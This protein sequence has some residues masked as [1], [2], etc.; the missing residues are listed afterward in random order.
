MH[1]FV[2]FSL[3]RS[4]DVFIAAAGLGELLCALEDI[5]SGVRI[6]KVRRFIS[7]YL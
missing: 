4:N 5:H 3:E 6:E 1:L 2:S 7:F